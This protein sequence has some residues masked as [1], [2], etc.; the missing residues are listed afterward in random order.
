MGRETWIRSGLAL[1]VAGIAAGLLLA[2]FAGNGRIAL[3]AGALVMVVCTIGLLAVV[4]GVLLLELAATRHDRELIDDVAVRTLTFSPQA[5]G[6]ITRPS[7]L[8]RV[9]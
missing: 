8:R 7:H 5:L 9:K 3:S 1:S 4:I 6:P 2:A